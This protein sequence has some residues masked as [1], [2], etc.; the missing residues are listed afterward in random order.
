MNKKLLILLALVLLV[1]CGSNESE[2][3]EE[4]STN[5]DEEVYVEKAVEAIDAFIEK[6]YEKLDELAGGELVGFFAE[7]ENQNNSN[8]IMENFG[9]F[10]EYKDNQVFEHEEAGMDL[11]IVQ[12]EAEFEKKDLLFTVT[13]NEDMELVGF[14]LK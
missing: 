13:F 10:K 7:P 8:E 3:P 4:T 2:V 11:V 5:I 6:D 9:E 1:G 12:Q 14:F